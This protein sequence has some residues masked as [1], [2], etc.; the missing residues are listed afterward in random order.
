[1]SSFPSHALLHLCQ[2]CCAAVLACALFVP[3]QASG[4]NA[5]I[6]GELQSLTSERQMLT[7]ELQQ[8]EKTLEILQTDGTPPEQSSNPAIQKLA[9][10]MVNIKQRL[11]AI[12]EREVTLLQEQIIA[13]KTTGSKATAIAS[14]EPKPDAIESKPLRAH[15]SEDT[16]AQE[17]ENV[18]RLHGLLAGYYTELQESAR[19]L[20]TAEEIAR[21]EAAQQ[22]AK[23]LAKIP[24]S[25]DKVRLNGA[26]GS[27]ALT[28]ITQRL[29]DSSIPESRRDIAPICVIK[30]RLY[31]S[32]VGSETRSLTPVGKNHFVAKVRLQPGDTT[33]NILASQWKL[34]LPHNV[35]ASD[36]LITLY[37]PPGGTPELHIFS[38]DDLLAE[39]KPHIPAWLPDDLKL[40][41]RAG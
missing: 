33:L 32:L 8:Y 4:Q 40:K 17:A 1:M 9:Q 20:P 15:G 35:N 41:A 3:L 28:L 37:R 22:D 36:F 23:Q 18:R 7:N 30:T 26:E 11:I 21:R 5:E 27:T 39:E 13:A 2:R 25:A 16:L 12:T 10:E 14:A 34:R 29:M 31:G 38:I 24:F 6:P 19:T